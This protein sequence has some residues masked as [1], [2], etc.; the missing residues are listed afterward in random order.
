LFALGLIGIFSPPSS[1]FPCGSSR[2]ELVAVGPG[3]RM[4]DYPRFR[5]NY[6]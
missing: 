3:P 2:R 4:A 6:T 1:L 5:S